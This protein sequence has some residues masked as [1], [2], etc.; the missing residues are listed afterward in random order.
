MKSI[1]TA[2][3]DY[4]FTHENLDTRKDE[5]IFNAISRQYDLCNMSLDERDMCMQMIHAFKSEESKILV[6]QLRD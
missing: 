4:I 3:L 6:N 1:E 2:I 5:E